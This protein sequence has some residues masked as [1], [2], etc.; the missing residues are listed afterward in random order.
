VQMLVL[1]W[2]VASQGNLHAQRQLVGPVQVLMKG[3]R[4]MIGSL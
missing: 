4:Q 1:C 3:A 2:A